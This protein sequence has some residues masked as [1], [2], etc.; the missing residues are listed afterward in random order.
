MEPSSETSPRPQSMQ[1]SLFFSYLPASQSWQADAP[2]LDQEPSPQ[3]WHVWRS[4]LDRFPASHGRQR[5]LF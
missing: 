4:S 3:G 1:L 5:S 2:V